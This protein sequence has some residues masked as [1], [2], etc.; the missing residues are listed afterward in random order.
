MS[1]YRLLNLACGAKVSQKGNWTNVDFSSPV[2]NVIEMNILKGLNF[3][4]DTFDVIY[5]A[6]FVEH[7]TYDQAVAVMVEVRR[8]MKPGG[9]LR[10]VTP[11]LEELTQEYLK[12]LSALKAEATPEDV[13][14]YD[15]IRLEIFDQIVRDHSGGEMVDFIEKCNIETKNYVADR[16]G[17]TFSTF[18]SQNSESAEESNFVKFTRKLNK[19]PSY[20][21][22]KMRD[23]TESKM[24]KV[25][26]FRQC[27]EVHR[28]LHDFFSLSKVLSDAGF[29]KIE[30]RS[31]EKSEIPDW[32]LYELD[33]IKGRVDGPYC[34]YIEAKK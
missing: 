9:I 29:D 5:S 34:L 14:K 33:I 21:L 27:G 30:R 1:D 11:D 7:L 15:W 16:I 4:N 24:K 28:Y 18:S 22:R 3:P 12:H 25:G 13:N 6:Q 23:L 17:Y 20:L 32:K 19:L 26:R 31:P 8:V 2:P 10:L